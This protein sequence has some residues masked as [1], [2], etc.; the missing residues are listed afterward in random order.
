MSRQNRAIHT[1]ALATAGALFLGGCGTGPSNQA[2]PATTKTHMTLTLGSGVEPQSLDPAQSREAQFVQYFQPVFDTLIRRDAA[3]KIQP[4]LATKWE[5]SADQKTITFTLRD[6]VTF[7]DGTKL[8]ADAV[9]GNLE[10]FK[11]S[12]GPLVAALTA[13]ATVAVV[14][15][16]TVKLVLSKPDPALIYALGGPGGYIQ[17]PANFDSPTVKTEPICSGP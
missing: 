13:V 1:L 8:T 11:N 9:K 12:S 7:T 4:M 2:A 10:R 17:S 3:G 15:A 6:D 5:T 14:D 16:K